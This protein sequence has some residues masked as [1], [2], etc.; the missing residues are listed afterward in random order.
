MRRI[1]TQL[2]SKLRA[3]GLMLENAGLIGRSSQGL[4]SLR[5]LRVIKKEISNW[6]LPL[7][8]EKKTVRPERLEKLASK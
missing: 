4:E 2:F 1:E 8:S 3:L 7:S 6:P 5:A